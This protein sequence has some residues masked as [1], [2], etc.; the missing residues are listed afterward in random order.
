LTSTAPAASPEPAG[1]V[2]S[3]DIVRGA[4][5]VLMAID[6][7][8]VYAGVPAG[9]P[10]PG[11]FF[12]RWITHF[13]APAFVFLA[14]TSAWLYG[15]RV[16]SP[17]ALGRWLL[18]RGAWLVL[19]ELT[20][21]RLAWTFNFA[22]GR[23]LLA[24]VLWVIGWCMIAMALLVRLPVKVVG[25]LGLLIIAGHNLTALMP[26]EAV[27]ALLDGGWGWL[28]RILYF[29]GPIGESPTLFVLYSFVPWI[30]V[31]AAGYAFGALLRGEARHRRRLCYGIG[32][33]ATAAFVVLRLLNVYGDRPWS[34]DGMPAVLAFL[35]TAKYP[36]SLLFLL[37]TLGPSIAVMPLLDEARGKVWDWLEVFGRV[38]FFFYLLHIPL[39][40]LMAVAVS[41]VRTPAATGWLFGDHPVGPPPVPDG[42]MWSLTLLYTVTALAVTTLYPLCR[43]FAALKRRRREAWLT[44]L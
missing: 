34:A 14:G 22:Y 29:G 3:I 18:T 35:N 42:Y 24:G 17:G 28:W 13:C 43:W 23:L 31:M 41:V 32:L 25:A 8:R 10:G 6:H 2:R 5:M 26:R 39:I 21:V 36:A 12:T 19:L 27:K 33:G 4:V 11:V 40:H 37:M 30:G 9:G 7:V 44:Y 15:R 20:V 38:P 1:R 16:G